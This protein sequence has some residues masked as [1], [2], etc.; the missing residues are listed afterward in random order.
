MRSHSCIFDHLEK[1]S[2]DQCSAQ[3]IFDQVD[4]FHEEVKRNWV[5]HIFDKCMIFEVEQNC[6]IMLGTIILFQCSRLR[7]N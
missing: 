4:I 3:D 5:D 6:L 1:G 2:P 7:K